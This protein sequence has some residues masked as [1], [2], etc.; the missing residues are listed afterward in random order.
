VLNQILFYES[1][2]PWLTLHL[3]YKFFLSQPEFRGWGSRHGREILSTD[4][5]ASQH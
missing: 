1:G 3:L 5:H 2:K 4:V